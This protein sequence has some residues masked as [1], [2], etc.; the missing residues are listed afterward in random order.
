MSPPDTHKS[1]T[2]KRNDDAD[3]Q[4][5]RF[6]S[7][8]QRKTEISPTYTPVGW[9]GVFNLSAL[10]G[11]PQDNSGKAHSSKGDAQKSKQTKLVYIT[12]FKCLIIEYIC[13]HT[14]KETIY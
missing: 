8:Q 14:E 5:L 11:S 7:R 4:H 10:D 13:Q 3:V 2:I 12:R 6:Q 9:V 1:W